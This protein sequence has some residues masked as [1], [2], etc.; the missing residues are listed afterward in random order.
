MPWIRGMNSISRKRSAGLPHSER[1]YM[2]P[3][4]SLR[5][6]SFPR[7]CQKERSPVRSKYPR[8]GSRVTVST[9]T[10]PSVE[11]VTLR[12]WR[13]PPSK[14][15]PPQSSAI[16]SLY[17]QTAGHTSVQEPVTAPSKGEPKSQGLGPDP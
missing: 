16:F 2:Y 11:T 7:S 9:G 15:I 13:G 12:A 5:I 14:T 6:A 1:R 10:G 8:K 4:S 3:P 17:R